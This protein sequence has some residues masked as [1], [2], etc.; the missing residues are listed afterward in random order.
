MMMEFSIETLEKLAAKAVTLP[1]CLDNRRPQIEDLSEALA[2]HHWQPACLTTSKLVKCVESLRNVSQTL[3]PII[4]ASPPEPKKRLILPM[5]V[6]IS[7]LATG[8]RDLFNDVQA[9]CW[10]ELTKR[11]QRQIADA[12]KTFHDAVPT[13]TGLLKLIRDKIGAHVDAG[14]FA[15]DLRDVWD[16]MTLADCLAWIRACAKFFWLMLAPDLYSWTR[17]STDADTLYLMN[18]DS[19]EV[20]IHMEDNEP[21]SIIRVNIARSPKWAP[22]EEIKVLVSNCVD[23]SERL[24][25]ATMADWHLKGLVEDT[26]RAKAEPEVTETH[27][28]KKDQPILRLPRKR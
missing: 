3:I 18:V 23:L 20:G 21:E 22:T 25:I 17:Q 26:A 7:N 2:D 4:A 14:L 16:Q 5:V 19:W 8:L 24:G 6:P 1:I 28:I 27:V 13:N 9:V 11:E 10:E 15:T 12:F